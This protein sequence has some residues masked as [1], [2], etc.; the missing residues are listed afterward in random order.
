MSTLR[1]PALMGL[2]LMLVVP[3]ASPSAQ[4][5]PSKPVRVIVPF[6]AGGPADVYARVIA[7]HLTEQ[8]K[9]SFVVENRPGAGAIIGTDAVAKSPPDGYTLLL[10]SNTH[11]T[12]ESLIPNKPFQLMRDFVPITPINSSD[13]LM[14]AHPATGAKNLKDFIAL[15][16]AKP[17]VLNYASSGPGTPYHMAGELFKAMSGT[18]IV[19]VPHKSSG[20]MRSS[21]MGGHVQMMFD[22]ITVMAQGVQSGQLVALGTTGEKRS[23]VMPEVPTVAEAGVP[24]YAATIWVGLMAPVGTP[25]PVI[26]TL[27]AEVIKIMNRSDVKEAWARQGAV[28]MPMSAAEFDKYLRADIEK[29]AH[30]VKVS[31]AKAE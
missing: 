4:T 30:V 6:G 31:G 1:I 5:Y 23:A 13:L 16:K 25:K 14:V 20:D 22:A 8:L 3:A 17:G 2:A 10:M 21:V 24:N 27:N 12:N 9:Q 11:T 19:H 28:P 18:D 7:Q 26:D 15:A 29:W